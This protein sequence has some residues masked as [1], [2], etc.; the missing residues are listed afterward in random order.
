MTRF[1]L[2]HVPLFWIGLL[3]VIILLGT[4]ADSTRY[5]SIWRYE[6]DPNRDF[7]LVLADSGIQTTW[8]RREILR[9]TDFPQVTVVPL[10]PTGPW[11]EWSRR[12][13]L[14]LPKRPWF[15]PLASAHD[16]RQLA[17]YLIVNMD[18]H[19]VPLWLILAGW[20]PLWC[21][22]T[23]CQAW[24]KGRRLHKEVAQL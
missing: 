5:T 13:G 6:V 7:H 1:P 22:A 19:L 24:R 2:R 15:P 3:P 8:Q 10:P 9:A 23:W 21:G 11:G 20:L 4:W 14:P 12:P 16:S 18:V 17:P